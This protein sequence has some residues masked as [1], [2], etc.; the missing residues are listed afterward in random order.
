[1][2]SLSINLSN[3]PH[4]LNRNIKLV[5]G[6]HDYLINKGA[7]LP[8][9]RGLQTENINSC[10]AGILISGDR[11]F[12]FHA[13]PELQPLSS[14]K[15]ELEKKIAD[16]HATCENIQG[17]IC[18]GWEFKANDKECVKSFDLYNT[19][20]N[21][22]DF[23]GVK[24]SMLCGKEKGSNMDNIFSINNS[25]TLWNENFNNIFKQNK[26]YT[27]NEIVEQLEKDYQFVETNSD[28]IFKIFTK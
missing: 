3:V 14:I 2:S 20:A 27:Q 19:I 21:V 28:D 8:I 16:L 25:V 5:G 26:G 11:H 12:M 6:A 18:G 10:T 4:I 7:N 1:M 17:F 15:K 24:F 9:K 13:A 23:L 22:F